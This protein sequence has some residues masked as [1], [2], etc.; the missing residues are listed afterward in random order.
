MPECQPV[1]LEPILAVDIAVPSDATPK[2]NAIVSSR[3]G[4]ILGFD[5]R[6]GWDGW[7]VVQA[8]IPEAEMADL[9][10]ELRSATSGVGTFRAR[11]DHL[12]ELTGRQADQ[13]VASRQAAQ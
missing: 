6:A 13:I 8:L 2:A 9:I 4:Q 12:A 11:F 3:R 1:L 10:I 5:G 7:D